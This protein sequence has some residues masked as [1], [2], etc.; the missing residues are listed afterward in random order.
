[1]LKIVTLHHEG[2]CNNEM[3]GEKIELTV[4]SL[5]TSERM[6]FSINIQS[7]NALVKKVLCR[8]TNMHVQY[9]E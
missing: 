4:L 1:M 2:R 6:C 9:E 5:I 8:K 3:D 7:D